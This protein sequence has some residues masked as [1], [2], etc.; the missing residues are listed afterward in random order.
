M[1]RDEIDDHQQVGRPLADRDSLVLHRRRQQRHGQR[2]AVLNHHQR[3]V[4]VRA[5]VESDR[6]RV[7]AVVARLGRHV[8]HAR[9]AVDLLLDRRADGIGHDVG[10][11]AGV[12]DG[13]RDAGRR[14]PRVLGHRQLEEGNAA[15]E[16]D[17]Q[18]EHRGKNR[19]VNKEAGNH[20]PARLIAA[21]RLAMRTCQR[22]AAPRRLMPAA[23]SETFQ[24][25]PAPPTTTSAPPPAPRRG[26]P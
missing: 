18:G 22:S 3:R 17:G 21:V 7:R 6:E 19:P 23:G 26:P 14:D 25:S 10:A 11:G 12:A 13:D 9:H 8:E 4:D 5:N 2:H 20:G 24:S 16:R 1:W 15:D